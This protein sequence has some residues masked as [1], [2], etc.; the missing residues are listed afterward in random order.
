MLAIL[1]ALPACSSEPP[2]PVPQ[3]PA[4]TSSVPP[5]AVAAKAV[6]RTCGGLATLGEVTEILNAAIT[7]QTLPV[8]GVPEPGIGRTARLDCYY[9]VPAGQPL[10]AAVVWI[11]LASYSDAGAARRRMDATVETER[12]AGATA[13]D[14]PVG[15]HRGI[16]LNAA[17][18]TLV[19]VRGNNTIV[20]TVLP[21]LVPDDQAGAILGRLADH[22]LTVR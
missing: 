8:V 9:G 7:G 18:R 2:A 11:G 19:A 20:I 17:R 1:A 22:A 15:P 6:P 12:E 3:V 21:D 16:L 4:F 10:S 13:N 14:V 5:S